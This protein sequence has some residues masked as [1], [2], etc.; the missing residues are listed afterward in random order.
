MEKDHVIHSEKGSSDQ[1]AE[2]K[3]KENAK[4][5]GKVEHVAINS[6]TTFEFPAGLSQEERDIRIENYK[7]RHNL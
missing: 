1:Q 6:R 7:K 2:N 3:S 5:A 4:R